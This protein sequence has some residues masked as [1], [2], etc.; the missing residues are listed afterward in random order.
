MYD[1]LRFCEVILAMCVL[2]IAVCCIERK[3]K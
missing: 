2:G 3:P 1:A